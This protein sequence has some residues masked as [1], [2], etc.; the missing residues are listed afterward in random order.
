[1]GRYLGTGL[2]GRDVELVLS[3]SDMCLAHD[4]DSHSFAAQERQMKV[5]LVER[6]ASC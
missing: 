3:V 5:V 2:K 4:H 1:M 6:R